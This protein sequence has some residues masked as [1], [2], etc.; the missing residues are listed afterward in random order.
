MSNIIDLQ[1]SDNDVESMTAGLSGDSSLAGSVPISANLFIKKPVDMDT[2]LTAG[3]VKQMTTD[4]VAAVEEKIATGQYDPDALMQTVRRSK[5]PIKDFSKLTMEDVYNL[6][7]PIEAKEFFN[8][9]SLKIT[10]KDSNYEARWVNKN[11]Q[12]LGNKIA[13]GFTYI[14]KEDLLT[15]DSIQAAKD[16]QGHYVFDD[17]V[18][19][20]IDKATYFAALRYAHLRAIAATDQAQSRRKAANL[21]NSYMTKNVGTDFANASS[22]GKMQFYDPDVRI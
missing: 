15:E 16:S 12:N 1:S 21:A 18:A 19:M 4:I 8:A 17:V 14:T 20:K 5:A 10:L 11:S 7:V 6:E 9:D 13:K 2:P 3:D 22:R